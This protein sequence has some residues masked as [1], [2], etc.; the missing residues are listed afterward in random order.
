MSGDANLAAVAGLLADHNRAE[1]VMAVLGGRPASGSSLAESAGISRSLASAH[2]RKLV[3]GGL[4]RV[5]SQGRQR[6]YS[7]ASD[8]VAEALEALILLAPPS[9][10]RSLRQ[11]T[12]SQNLRWARLCYDHLAGTLGVAVTEALVERDLIRARDG[13]FELGPEGEAGFA[14]LG[15]EVAALRA[16]RRRLLRACLDWSERRDHV[17]GSLGAAMTSALIERRWLRRS[18]A[19][20]VVTLTPAGADGLESWLGLD[21][22][23]L[24]EAA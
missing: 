20:R 23:E 19:S 1:M 7:L 21:L 2:L 13:D 8:Q 12:R 5:E 17:A 16:K 4:L 6:L 24:R 11:A 9:E 3:D 22:A 15:V 18:E 14:E 10:V